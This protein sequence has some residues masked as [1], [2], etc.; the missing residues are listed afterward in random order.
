MWFRQFGRN[1]WTLNADV[2]WEGFNTFVIL[3]QFLSV[4]SEIWIY[5]K[6]AKNYTKIQQ[7][8]STKRCHWQML[9]NPIRKRKNCVSVRTICVEKK[10]RLTTNAINT[11]ES[12]VY[13]FKDS[14]FNFSFRGFTAGTGHEAILNTFNVSLLLVCWTQSPSAGQPSGLHYDEYDDIHDN[15]DC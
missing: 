13:T 12:E 15:Y 3:F 2:A 5:A 14:I 11:N 1:Y 7:Y 9:V 8:V 6:R 10:I 4:W